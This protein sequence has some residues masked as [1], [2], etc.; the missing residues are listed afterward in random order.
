[1][2]KCIIIGETYQLDRDLE[3]NKLKCPHCGH[4]T[5]SIR[6]IQKHCKDHVVES[7]TKR[8]T[9]RYHPYANTSTSDTTKDNSLADNT[10]VDAMD[11]EGELFHSN[12]F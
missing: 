9:G 3:T 1:M 11:I 12:G 5:D 7:K 4:T 6:F 8:V 10:D 2:I